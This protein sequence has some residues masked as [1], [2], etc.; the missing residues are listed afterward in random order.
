MTNK[1]KQITALREQISYHDDL[2]Y[3]KAAP[4]ISDAEYDAMK[5]TL[6][7]LTGEES[8]YVPDDKVDGFEKV[9]HTAP[10][11]SLDKVNTESDLR[12]ALIMLAPGL[13]QAK[14]DGLTLVLYPDGKAV[15]RGDGLTGDDL[16]NAARRISGL[17]FTHPNFPVRME[18]FINDESFKEVQRKRIDAGEE[19][20][21]NPRNAAAGIIRNKDVSKVHG[22]DFLAYNLVGDVRRDSEQLAE[23]TALGVKTVPSFAYTADTIDEAV[24]YCLKFDRSQ[25]PY[26]IDGLVIKSDVPNALARFGITGHHPKSAIAFKFETEKTKTQLLDVAWEVGRTGRITPVAVLKPCEL[27]GTTVSRASLHNLN[28]MNALGIRKNALVTLHK[29]NEII[30]QIL[31][32]EGGDE[33]FSTPKT[34]PGCGAEMTDDDI[35]NGQPNCPNEACVVRKIFHLTHAASRQALNIEGLSV[36]TA[37]KILNGGLESDWYAP[38]GWG[39][40]YRWYDV[41]GF[42][43]K[44]ATKM[45]NAVVNATHLPE[46]HR[47]LYAAG[48][49]NVGKTACKAMADKFGSI[50]AILADIEQ[51]DCREIAD[52]DGIGPVIVGQIQKY[53]KIWKILLSYCYPADQEIKQQKTAGEQKIFVITGTLSQSRSYFEKL[54]SEAGHKCSGSISKKTNY[55]LAGADAGSKLSKAHDAGVQVISEGELESIL[56]A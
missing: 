36:E 27:D 7:I 45:A 55:L 34:C 40:A 28:I 22:L 39:D 24:E 15:T 4:Q 12:A 20:F 5:D 3:K 25:L 41:E 38:L 46:L 30:P 37:S 18:V 52:I 33:E 54:I 35:E 43:D 6:R 10:I 16:S 14:I 17:N 9:R 50:K 2:Y 44:S 23:L 19:S 53:Y 1:E 32:S 48:I 21:K 56:R 49:K 11:Q 51:N 13:I 31:S 29:A 42:A 8:I 47:F 26:A